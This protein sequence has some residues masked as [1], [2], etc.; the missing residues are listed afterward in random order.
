[1]IS[2]YIAKT[3]HI[4]N[5]MLVTSSKDTGARDVAV[6]NENQQSAVTPRST[7][8]ETTHIV[9]QKIVTSSKDTGA[10]DVAV[11]NENQQS[12]V[13]SHKFFEAPAEY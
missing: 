4:V 13:T 11:R 6:R 9:N 8:Q 2:Q 1:M 3:T 12:A 5:Q 10:R 7:M